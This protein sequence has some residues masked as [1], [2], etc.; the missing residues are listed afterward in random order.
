MVPMSSCITSAWRGLCLHFAFIKVLDF[1]D[2][3]HYP[4]VGANAFHHLSGRDSYLHFLN[5]NADF[6]F[7]RGTPFRMENFPKTVSGVGE[8]DY[9]TANCQLLITPL[10]ESK[11]V[12]QNPDARVPWSDVLV[13]GCYQTEESVCPICLEAPIL[14]RMGP[15]G[16]VYCYLCVSCYISFENDTSSKQCAVCGVQLRTNDLRRV[17]LFSSHVPNVGDTVRLDLMRRHKRSIFPMVASEVQ[18]RLEGSGREANPASR[19]L[20]RLVVA[21]QEDIVGLV[22]TD[23]ATMKAFLAEDQLEE[24]DEERFL[25]AKRILRKLVAEKRSMEEA[26][27]FT[28]DEVSFVSNDTTAEDY[29]FYYQEVSGHDIYLHSIN[30]RCLVEDFGVSNLPQE[31]KGKVVEVETYTM[32]SALR[33]RYRHLRHLPLGRTFHLIEIQFE[34]PIISA[35]TLLLVSDVLTMRQHR[36]EQKEARERSL[37][38]AKEKAEDLLLSLPA[39]SRTLVRTSW[40]QVVPTDEDFVPLDVAMAE[41]LSSGRCHS[42]PVLQ[43]LMPSF[44]SSASLLS[45]AAATNGVDIDRTES[46]ERVNETSSWLDVASRGQTMGTCSTI[47]ADTATASG[48]PAATTSCSMWFPSQ[49]ASCTLD[50]STFAHHLSVAIPENAQEAVSAPKSR[51]RRRRAKQ[52]RVVD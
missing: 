38:R 27:V 3:Q 35:E 8:I 52:S 48:V 16:H 24:A 17:R 1:V 49:M 39:E 23:I 20:S 22:D 9:V 37:T 25:I 18:G 44:S 7:E 14:P 4:F 47:A 45:T 10:N 26:T 51:R 34:N 28:R 6:G 50:P 29:F 33:S 40:T 41:V 12:Y 2:E 5:G 13:V 15:C 36:R 42:S 32:S 43:S 31:I 30:W 11:E 19:F 46:P 21:K